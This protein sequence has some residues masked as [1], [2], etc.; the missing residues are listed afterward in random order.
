ML[1]Q[2]VRQQ[3]TFFLLGAAPGH[4]KYYHHFLRI[5]LENAAGLMVQ[6]LDK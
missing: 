6:R 5:V 1:S 4:V 3:L 2:P